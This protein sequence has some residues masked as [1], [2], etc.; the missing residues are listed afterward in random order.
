MSETTILHSNN[1]SAPAAIYVHW[2]FCL[3]KCP[4]C[5]FNS[6]V[7]ESVDHVSWRQ[8]FLQEI[9][10]FAERFPN[11]SA[12]SIFFG[13]G[14]PSL[15]EPE[16]TAIIIDAIRQK[17]GF[18]NNDIEI[19]LEANPSSIEAD[20]F[21]DYK[22]AGVNRI[23]VGIQS[24][25]DDALKF[26]G[27]LHNASEAIK[28]LNVAR[29]TFARVSFDL[30]YA[31]PNQTLMDWKTELSEALSFDPS[32]LSLYQLTIEEGTAFYHQF[33]RGKFTLPDEEDSAELYALTQ[34]LTV[35]AGLPAYEISNHA[36]YGEKSRHNLCY[37]QGDYYIGLGPGAHGRL[38]GEKPF[39]A[40]AHSQVKR[41]ED[42]LKAIAHQK[43][44]INSLDHVTPYDRAI[45]II[46]MGL[47]LNRGLDKASFK[48][49]TGNP[50]EA[51][52]DDSNFEALKSEGFL[53]SN[54]THFQLTEK[55]LPLLNAILAKLLV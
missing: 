35:S 45:E 3:K 34:D 11:L 2:P 12:K 24:L 50:I 13:G 46:M 38:P 22:G 43:S 7:R 16:T 42:W 25:R 23:S 15:M 52:I 18:Q 9:D 41:P 53:T 21:R 32:H 28:A 20:R 33:H 49:K 54:Q 55:G 44:G 30:I 39:S 37:W 40:I 14:T 17:W 47:R 1:I 10:F 19:T 4:Y 31:R 51:Y 8:A 26:L 29:E 36:R 48:E 27:R 5:D 6:H